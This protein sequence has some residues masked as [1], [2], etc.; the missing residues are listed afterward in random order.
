MYEEIVRQ[1]IAYR[2]A[3]KKGLK[4]MKESDVWRGY[5]TGRLDVAESLLTLIHE[6]IERES[7]PFK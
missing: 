5:H 3:S 1:L 4:Q 6:L 2:D 7:N